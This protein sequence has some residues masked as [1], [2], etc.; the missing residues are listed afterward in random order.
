[1]ILFWGPKLV[2]IYN[3]S[4]IPIFGARH[5]KALGK[6]ALE[7]W[8]EVWDVIFPMFE[9]VFKGEATWSEDQLLLLTRNGYLEEC[10][11]TWSYTPIKREDGCVEG[12]LTP[13]TE[14]TVRVLSN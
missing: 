1:M 9:K 7:A 8:G 4:Y 3:D 5:P 6:T 12:I 11:F 10:Y 2:V 13:I 14:T